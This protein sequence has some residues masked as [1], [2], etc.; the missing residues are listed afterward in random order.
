MCLPVSSN[1]NLPHSRHRHL[2]NETPMMNR[3]SRRLPDTRRSTLLERSCPI[4]VQATLRKIKQ[5]AA[6]SSQP[7]NHN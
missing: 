7:R 1:R 5:K 3:R 2:C 4:A 6:R